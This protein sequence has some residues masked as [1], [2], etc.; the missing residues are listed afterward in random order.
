MLTSLACPYSHGSIVI[1]TLHT[2]RTGAT[3]HADSF[4]IAQL[5]DPH[6]TSLEGVDWRELCN[7]RV[8]GY[9]SWRRRRRFVHSPEVLADVVADIKAREFDHIAV[10]GDLTHVGLPVEC[11]AVATW[12]SSLGNAN[13]VTVIPGNHDRYVR[14]DWSETV[15]CWSEYLAGDDWQAG[16]AGEPMFPSLR[17]RDG[18]AIIGVD[19][20]IP[21]APLF[22]TGRTGGAQRDR[23]AALLEMA[24]RRGLFRL[25]LIHHSPLPQGHRWRKRLTDAAALLGVLEHQGAELVVHGHGHERRIDVI[26][27][28]RG[29]M[30]V[31][32]APSASLVGAG[33]GGYNGYQ[34]NTTDTGWHVELSEYAHRDGGVVVRDC[35]EFE[36]S[37]S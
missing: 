24:Q 11:R 31:V 29:D 37:R 28:P 1:D 33:R 32:A 9:L 35:R 15:G 13:Q 30:V 7:K 23:V 26:A 34:I 22:A 27:T 5:S 21:S 19:S 14:A 4:R 20:A 18:V 10:T 17:V 8:L 12:L 36:L 2:G 3:G 25:V 6:L 16:T